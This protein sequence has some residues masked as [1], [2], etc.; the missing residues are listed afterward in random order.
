MKE[1]VGKLKV[2]Y[3]T[4]QKQ[5]DVVKLNKF[6]TFDSVCSASDEILLVSSNVELKVY[7]INMYALNV[8]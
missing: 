2:T 6:I 3:S 4:E 7:L 8:V 1:E 5:M